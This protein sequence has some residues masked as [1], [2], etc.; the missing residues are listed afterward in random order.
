MKTTFDL[1]ESLVQDIKHLARERGTTARSIVQQALSRAVA[2]QQ[3]TDFV[4]EDAGA[5]GWGS[6]RQEF[7][8]RSLHELVLASY[9]E[10]D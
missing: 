1:P 3:R 7:Q 10:R 6:M 2:E 9:S 5:A 4:L 8:A